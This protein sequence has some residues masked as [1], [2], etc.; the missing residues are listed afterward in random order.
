M[1]E[2]LAPERKFA[3]TVT[4][5]G[6]CERLLTIEI[7]ED[8]VERERAHIVE[9]L[10]RELK[11][12]GF[13]KGKVPLSFVQKNYAD[14][15]HSDAVRNLLPEVYEQV[16]IQEHLHP[17]AEPNFEN[18]RAE[19]GEG[20]VVE[21]KVEVRPEIEIKDFR[22]VGVEVERKQVG[23]KDVDDTMQGLR[24][25]TAVLQ[26]TDRAAQT[27][28]YVTVDY[29]PYLE[30]G[31]VDEKARQSN[32]V[33]ELG[34]ENLLE[35]FRVGL[36]GMKKDDEKDLDVAY[37]DDFPDPALAGDKRKFHVKVVEVK[38]KLLPELDD[39]FAKSLGEK[40]DSMDSLREQVRTDLESEEKKRHEHEIEEKIVDRLIEGNAFEVP[41]VMVSNY[42]SSVL[43]EDRRRRPQVE[44][45]AARENE[46]RELFT[47]AAVR[48]I[49]KFMI[50]EAVRRQE[51]ITLTDE[52]IDGKIT[53]LAEGAGKPVEELRDLLKDPGRRRGFEGDLLDQKVL[54]FLRDVVAIKV[55]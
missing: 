30:S 37:S 21:A 40:F 19:P 34:A 29:A 51:N 46:V 8:E 15:I 10:R 47:D 16:L 38:E 20:I 22:G 13:R 23:D 2:E 36:V 48:S 49:K 52:D 3:V 4:S 55:A 54:N 42:L 33:V 14:V 35:E 27:S 25:R 44:D 32:Y 50:L 26:S 41:K 12:P 28:D 43:E 11:V 9:H 53:S 5:P 7:P 1:A 18:L 6:E 17:L 31:E 24:E 39:S 45:E